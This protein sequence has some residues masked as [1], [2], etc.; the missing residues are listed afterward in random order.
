MLDRPFGR[1]SLLRGAGALSAASLASWTA[2]CAPDDN[3]L[4]FFFASNPDERDVR[5]RIVDEFRAA[6]PT[7]RFGRCCRRR[8]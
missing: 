6:T 4:T 2:G 7:S 3:A 1:R 5:M 8:A